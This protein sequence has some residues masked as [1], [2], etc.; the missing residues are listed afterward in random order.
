MAVFLI[1]VIIV[2]AKFRREIRI[3]TYT[4]FNIILPCQ[5]E[6]MFEN[7]RYDAFV[8]YSS[9]DQDWVSKVFEHIET[10]ENE[11]MRH[12]KFCLHHRDFIPGKTIFDN[13]I[14]S[15]ETSR[16]T[17]IVLSRNFLNSH[18]CMYEFHEAFQQSIIERKKH[19]IVILLEDIPMAELPNDLKRCLKT[20]TYIKKDDIIFEDRL[21]FALSYKGIK[22]GLSR[23][24]SESTAKTLTSQIS[25]DTDITSDGNMS[26]SVISTNSVFPNIISPDDFINSKREE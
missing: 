3:L 8:S 26:P 21:V 16:H 5:H 22:R 12:F 24:E 9:A 15:V 14:D 1:A 19:L 4:R 10:S 6:E 7:K 18:Y 2:L 25:R 20:F 17:V 23:T 11:L 13:V